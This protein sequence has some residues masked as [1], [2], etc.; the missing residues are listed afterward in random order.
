MTEDVLERMAELDP[1]R[2]ERLDQVAAGFKRPEP[3]DAPPPRRWRTLPAV[4]A[5][6]VVALG[7]LVPIVL[8]SRS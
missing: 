4:V 2:S 5:A 6:A 7:L 8:L 1:A 3:P